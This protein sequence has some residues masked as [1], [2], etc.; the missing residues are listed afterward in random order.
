[1]PRSSTIRDAAS[2]QHATAVARHEGQ[3]EQTRQQVDG[4]EHEWRLAMP[5]TLAAKKQH[6][7]EARQQCAGHRLPCSGVKSPCRPTATASGRHRLPLGL[8]F[9]PAGGR[10]VTPC[11]VDVK[12]C[13]M[14]G[15]R[16]GRFRYRPPRILHTTAAATCG[17]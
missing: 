6:A 8:W 13:S 16:R 12:V 1:M 7:A 11:A 15:S 4:S 14:S 3:V 17:P 9:G 10:S 2:P 5:E